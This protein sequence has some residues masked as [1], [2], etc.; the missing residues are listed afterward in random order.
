VELAGY[1]EVVKRW[2]AT[3]LIATWV[4]G[5][6]GYLIASQI[7]PTY[8]GEVHLLVG[9]VVGDSDTLRAAGAISYTYAELAT[10]G[11]AL[12]RAAEALGLP[13]DTE[14]V[15][16]AIP[17]E[18]TRILAIRAQHSDA[19]VAATI[20]N[21]LAG[22]LINEEG[23]GV[24]LPEGELTI[25]DEAVPSPDPIA[26]QV[27]LIALIAAAMGLLAAA[28]LV[29]LVDYFGNTV[30]SRRE[31]R[32]VARVP[33]LGA[34]ALGHRF[35]PTREMPTI[36]EKQPESRAAAAVRFIA[37][38]L[39]YADPDAPTST[40][41]IIGC[42]AHDGSAD[43]TL[44][45]AA[46]LAG[47]G[48]RVI[49]IDANDEHGELSE[50]ASIDGTPGVA[51]LLEDPTLDPAALVHTRARGPSLLSRGRHARVDLVDP[52]ACRALAGRLAQQYEV[53]LISAAPI[54]HS[55]NGLVWARA[56]ERVVLAVERD[57]AKRDDVSYALENLAAVRAPVLGTVLLERAPKPAARRSR[58]ANS[59]AYAT[60]SQAVGVAARRPTPVAGG[61]VV[62]RGRGARPSDQA[63]R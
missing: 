42:A 39:A 43:L 45:I 35:R 9:P 54:H 61:P 5:L 10:S 3:L 53:V 41:L 11:P 28:V 27:T 17:N 52:D 48:R 56:T 26:P 46:A 59:A 38:K 15:A 25:V 23:S 7:S 22:Q 47:S 31:L 51:E 44:G 13:A 50:L 36:V 29:L 49:A 19:T 58:A 16:R 33:L 37:T 24:I 1:F 60:R 12:D 18:T 4:A 21:E 40:A 30:N 57:R 63:S 20:A 62:E 6:A 55:G 34:A 14:I 32:E 8:E 2:W